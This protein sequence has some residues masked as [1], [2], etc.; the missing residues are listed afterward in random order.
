MTPQNWQAMGA[1]KKV[2]AG[3]LAILIGS[4]GIHKFILGYK[5]EGLIMLLGTLLTCGV[6]AAVFGVIGVIEGILYLVKSD[7]EFVRTYIQ[8]KKGWF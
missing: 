7:E 2:T 6:A 1:D 5:T 4:L 8:N 3:V